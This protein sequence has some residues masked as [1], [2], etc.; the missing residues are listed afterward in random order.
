MLPFLTNSQLII[1]DF[2]S[3]FRRLFIDNFPSAEVILTVLPFSFLYGYL[4]LRI[5]GTI[6]KNYTVRTGLTRKF[7]H[8]IVFLTAGLLQH[9][10]GLSHTL[11]F[12]GGISLVVLLALLKGDGYVLYEALAREQDEP[13]RA[14]YIIMPYFATLIGGLTVNLFFQPLHSFTGY[15]ITGFGDAVGEPV[16]VK[17]GKHK[18]KVPSVSGVISFRSIE[19]SIAVFL[20][21]FLVFLFVAY[22]NSVFIGLGLTGKILIGSL[23]ITLIEA[24]SPHGWDNFTTMLAGSLLSYWIF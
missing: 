5:A 17:W 14:R 8:F 11:V 23:L 4:V 20:S 21:V 7:F 3:L 9:N 10:Y 6:K 12:G 24:V 22:L 15:F 1:S 16:G 18:Y 13:T 2:F 19:G